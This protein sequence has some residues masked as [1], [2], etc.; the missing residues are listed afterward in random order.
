[1][2]TK[3]AGEK[4][5][6]ARIR[7][8]E[9]RL[10][11]SEAEQMRFEKRLSER[12][13]EENSGEALR[14]AR[15][16]VENSRVVLFRR[17]LG[18]GADNR[19]DYISENVSQ[20]GYTAEEF[21]SGETQYKDILHPEDMERMMAEIQRYGESRE[22]VYEQEY[23]IMTKTGEFRWAHDRT[24]VILNEAGAPAYRQGIVV[25]IHERKLAEEALRK[26][27][28]KF[29]RTLE[30][31]GEGFVFMDNDMTILEV[32]DA[33]CLML[34]FAREDL[35]G[36]TPLDLATE[37][38]RRFL[39]SARE[40]FKGMEYRRFEGSL[41]ARDGRVVPVLINSNTLRD[42]KGN[43]LGHVAFVTDLTDQ[44]KALLLAEEV[45]KSLLPQAAPF[46][47]G[48]E[49]AGRSVSCDEI[50]GD[51]FDY[52]EMAGE[53]PG[54]F[55][56]VVGDIS[57]HGV[58]AALLMT[59][60]RAFFRMRAS[61]PGSLSE[62]VSD[63]N[64]YLAKDLEGTGRFMTLFSL[65][66]DNASGQMSWVRAGHDP[67]MV[68]SPI[69]DGFIELVGKGL[70][71]GIVEDAVYEELRLETLPPG[72]VLAV[73]TDGIWEAMDEKGLMFGKERFREIVRTQAAKGAEDILA[74]V[75]EALAGFTRGA[76][77]KDD[78]TLV[79]IKRNDA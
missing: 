72:G 33:Y 39:E 31:A 14:L 61:K 73:G 78:I 21:L 47:E 43:K 77:P 32:N 37:E 65:L 30:T 10:E 45:Q 76:R 25:D 11:A 5:L 60:A 19:L 63:M 18:Q 67:A 4:A 52:F 66:I 59:T 1:M 62:V 50:G 42:A 29:R 58:D 12:R 15:I 57:G 38:Y 2:N 48:L 20:W 23:R 17:R 79:V 35:L 24:T 75:Y 3:N 9:A 69:D 54:S 70:P 8:L 49:V 13:S 56:T 46:L 51:Y 6:L 44:K 74:A 16:I 71:L 27:E 36:K 34:G 41:L 68:Y 28:E 64:R 7:E 53:R 40:R 22:E 26:S 55:G